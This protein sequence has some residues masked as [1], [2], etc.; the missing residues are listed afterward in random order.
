MAGVFD[1]QKELKLCVCVY[2]LWRR[3]GASCQDGQQCQDMGRRHRCAAEPMAPPSTASSFLEIVIKKETRHDIGSKLW[4]RESRAKTQQGKVSWHL[5]GETKKIET[6]LLLFFFFVV[7]KRTLDPPRKIEN[8]DSLWRRKFAGVRARTISILFLFCF[9]CWCPT[10]EIVPG[11][12]LR[13]KGMAVQTWESWEEENP[14][15]LRTAHS[16][17]SRQN[18]QSNGGG[19]WKL[20]FAKVNRARLKK[21]N[22]WSKFGET[23]GRKSGKTNK[24]PQKKLEGGDNNNK[25]CRRVPHPQIR[26]WAS[27]EDETDVPGRLTSSSDER[28]KK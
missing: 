8:D 16:W 23:D 13:A 21:K 4:A 10:D 17:D 19:K 18:F 11:Q 20:S 26:R 6:D 25:K 15:N 7:V 28:K 2:S 9:P 24:P 14:G 3:K 22:S 12:T 1:T 27:R 5:S